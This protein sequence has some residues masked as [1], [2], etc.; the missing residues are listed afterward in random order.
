LR[1][2]P[3]L[4]YGSCLHAYD[5]V[6]GD[7]GAG[8]LLWSLIPFLLCFRRRGQV[9]VKGH[10]NIVRRIQRRIVCCAMGRVY[11][12]I[13]AVTTR[14]MSKSGILTITLGCCPH[15]AGHKVNIKRNVC[16]LPV[17]L[18][19]LCGWLLPNFNGRVHTLFTLIAGRCCW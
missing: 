2:S 7:C 15:L 19:S 12:K 8:W 11:R 1:L 18:W 14:R 13:V 10:F 16:W 4:C 3:I 5:G 6:D 17:G 9:S